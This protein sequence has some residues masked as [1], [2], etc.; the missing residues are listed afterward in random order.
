MLL[1]GNVAEH[2]KDTL[3]GANLCAFNRDRG[4]FRLKAVGNTLR[5][6]AT[7]V[8]Q[9]PIAHGLGNHFRPTQLGLER[10]ESCETKVHAVRQYLNGATHQR[11]LLKSDFAT[12]STVCV[13][14]YFFELPEK[15]HHLCTDCC[16]RLIM[17]LPTYILAKF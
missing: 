13:V 3:C 6:P 14:T 15:R 8:G 12:R 9:K 7:K 11:V 2:I 5:R 16:G 1:L 17:N 4:S 10:K